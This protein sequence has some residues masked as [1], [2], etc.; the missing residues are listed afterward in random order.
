MQLGGTSV[1]SVSHFIKGC[2]C[3]LKSYITQD[4]SDGP[5]VKILCF[6]CRECRLLIC[7]AHLWEPCVSG[8][9]QPDQAHLWT[10]AR[11]RKGHIPL[12]AD[13]NQETN[14]HLSSLPFPYKRSLNST[15]GKMVLWDMSPPSSWFA[16]SRIKLL[17]LVPTTHLL[18]YGPAMQ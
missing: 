8:D 7:L 13:Q 9:E 10:T 18:I 11:R 5:V 16:G 6:L 2:A 17:F 4:F 1:F 15:S 3:G 12:E 14:V